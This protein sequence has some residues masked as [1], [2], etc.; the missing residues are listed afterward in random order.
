M[1]S[2]LD[3]LAEHLDIKEI[4]TGSFPLSENQITGIA[5]DI[6][7]Y[8]STFVLPEVDESQ[9]PTYLGGWPSANFW[10]AEQSPLVMTT[11]LY[12]GQV[13]VKDPLADWFVD[14]S[15]Y[16]PSYRISKTMKNRASYRNLKGD[17]NVDETKKFL[18]SNIPKLVYFRQLIDRGI[19]IPVPFETL[20][21]R[22]QRQITDL[23]RDLHS[24][25]ASDPRT[26]AQRFAP[27]NLPVTDITRGMFVFAGGDRHSKERQIKNAIYDSLL[28]FA[29]EY[30]L[31]ANLGFEYSAC[32]EYE[33]HICQVGLE[34]MPLLAP[35]QRVLNAMFNS[36]LPLYRG[37]TPD[38]VLDL[39][40][41]KN[42]ADFRT[43]LYSTYR[44]LP[45]DARPKE[46][47]KYIAEAEAH[48]LNPT[49]GQ[50]IKEV[51]GGRFS[52]LGGVKL[53]DKAAKIGISVLIPAVFTGGISLV[54]PITD[55]VKSLYE[56]IFAR[57]K[58]GPI[59]L[60]KKLYRHERNYATEF[61]I[62]RRPG[63]SD[64]E[65]TRRKLY[66]GIPD[67]PSTSVHISSAVFLKD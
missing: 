7:A 53:A 48:Y 5:E 65:S 25:I 30:I 66:W 6:Q 22:Y 3:I 46:L 18:I 32:F 31:T 51:E 13:L 52:R 17:L 62:Q 19:I 16:E 23:S 35:G 43:Q 10:R 27:E 49:I 15:H 56:R 58:Q 38:I 2:T 61:D 1:V 36:E 54:G 26:F 39:R 63:E 64:E 4:E 29:S 9:H 45:I 57:K 41:D 20:E 40:D 42:F 11:L 28:Y 55:G 14:R 33:Q 44:D 37:L 50:A 21:N 59:I 12:S 60:W 8:S 47:K 67:K 24:I 34:R